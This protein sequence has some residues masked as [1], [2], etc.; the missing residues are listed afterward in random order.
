MIPVIK[1]LNVRRVERG[2]LGFGNI[3]ADIS[4]WPTKWKIFNGP[5]MK[6]ADRSK[7]D[8][9]RGRTSPKFSSPSRTRALSVEPERARACQNSHRAFFEPELSTDKNAKIWVR[10]Y[11]EPFGK[12]DS[13]SLGLIFCEPKFW[14]GPPSLGSFHHKTKALRGFQKK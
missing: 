11:F 3:D 1:I 7:D 4:S 14:P 9:S 2:W 10:V 12:L 6:A 5:E 8:Q 13:S